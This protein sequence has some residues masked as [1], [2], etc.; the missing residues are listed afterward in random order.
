[1]QTETANPN[2]VVRSYRPVYLDHFQAS[3]YRLEGYQVTAD[4]RVWACFG[5][6][7]RRLSIYPTERAL[8]DAVWSDWRERV[9]QV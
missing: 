3:M 8:L 1:M 7:S 4:G 5:N 6:G 2:A 9:R